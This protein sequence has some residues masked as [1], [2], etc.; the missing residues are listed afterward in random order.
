MP[1]PFA[2]LVSHH[3]MFGVTLR[4]STVADDV[5]LRVLL[6]KLEQLA[7]EREGFIDCQWVLAETCEFSCY[8]HSQESADGW[9]N[10]PMLRRVVSIGNQCWFESYHIS[11]FTVDRQ[12]SHCFPHV[13]VASMRFPKIETPRGQLVVLGLEHVSLLHDYVNRF[14]AHLAPWEPERTD[15][16]Y[17]E[18]TCRLRIREM[19]RDFLNDRGVVLCL[20]DK[21]GTR[22]LAYSNFSRFHRGISQS[23]ELG[24]SVAADVEGQG[25]MNECLVAGIHY[26]T[27]EL[28][29]DR[30][31]A[32][33]L[34]RNQR[35]GAVL[36]RL[37]FEKE[38][39]AK[40]YLKINGVWEDH[41]LTALVLR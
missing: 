32:C 6:D 5:M 39:L 24:Y 11:A 20:L 31:E 16:Y 7:R 41:V 27:A 35:S 19:R 21:A 18:E 13:D 23:C 8:W 29:I 40:N 37:G 25:Y 38:G 15:D 12:D 1:N 14:K 30:I 2:S 10:H 36:S 3:Q 33:Y 9:M 28:N 26:V 22:M 34:P 4:T 17:S